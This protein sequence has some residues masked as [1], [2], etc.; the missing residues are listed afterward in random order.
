[1]QE[2]VAAQGDAMGC[3]V[4][5]DSSKRTRDAWMTPFGA[6]GIPYVFIVSEGGVVFWSGFPNDLLDRT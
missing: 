1:M 4:A 5:V 2:F 6:S 3:R